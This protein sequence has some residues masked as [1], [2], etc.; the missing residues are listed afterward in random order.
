MNIHINTYMN[1]YIYI[2]IKVGNSVQMPKRGN[3]KDEAV[4]D[5]ALTKVTYVDIYGI[6][7]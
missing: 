4:T 6:K 2:S 5:K 1:I 3:F 7:K